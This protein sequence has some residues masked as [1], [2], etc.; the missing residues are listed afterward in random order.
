MP[1]STVCRLLPELVAYSM[2]RLLDTLIGNQTS[3]Q[4][5]VDKGVFATEI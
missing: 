3:I 1:L 5:K 4:D 2:L